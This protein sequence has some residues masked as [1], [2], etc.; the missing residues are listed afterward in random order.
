MRGYLDATTTWVIPYSW[1]IRSSH[2][3]YRALWRPQYLMQRLQVQICFPTNFFQVLSKGSLG[4]RHWNITLF[5]ELIV[6]IL[7]VK[8]SVG[9]SLF[10][11]CGEIL[12][13]CYTN[14][15]K[16]HGQGNFS[17]KIQKKSSHFEEESYEITKIF[18]RIWADFYLHIYLIGSHGLPTC[19]KI[20]CF[21]KF[22]I[23][24]V[25]QKKHTV[26]NF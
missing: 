1:P 16:Q 14:S 6:F 20:P 17:K 11:L 22:S 15:P 18:L 25:K 24:F 23:C 4:T 19:N 2:F 13:F 10:F 7:E 21:F 9:H 8:T 3:C 26:L 5:L 12:P